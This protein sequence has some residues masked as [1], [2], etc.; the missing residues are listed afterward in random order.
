MSQLVDARINTKLKLS[1]L[2]VSTLFCY[3]YCDYFELYVPGKLDSMLQGEGPFGPVGQA[4]L[5]V[6]SI[7]MAIPS[8]MVFLSIALPARLSRLLNIVF[9]TLFTLMMALLTYMAGWYFY[10]FFAA[11]ETILTALVVWHAWHWPKVDDIAPW[12]S[13][14]AS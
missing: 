11:V 5:A 12:K 14:P 6:T 7:I 1:T 9:G 8:L 3:I 2:W 4:D 13:N 10:K